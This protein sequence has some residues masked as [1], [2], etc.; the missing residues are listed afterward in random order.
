MKVIEKFGAMVGDAALKDPEKARRLLL[1][2]YRLQEQRLRFFPDKEIPPSGQ[3]AALVVMKNMIQ[4]LAKPD[5]A[6]MVSIFVPGELVTAAGLTPY[7][8]EAISCFLAG[9]KCEQAF[10]RKTL[11]EGFPETMCSYHRVFLGAALTEILP[12]PRCMIYTNLA[13][14]GNMMTFPYLKQTCDRPGFYIDVPYEK[15]RESVLY[16]ADQLRKL[17]SFLEDVTGRKI[18]EEAVRQS[19]LNSKKAAE[20][21]RKQLELRKDHDPVTSLTYELYAI[22][23][24]HLLAGSETAVRYTKLLLE[25][26]KKAPKGEGLHILWMHIMPF[27]QEPVKEVFNYSKTVHLSACDFVADGFRQMQSDDPYEAMAEKMVYCIYNGNVS[28][29]IELAK[30]LARITNADGGILFAHWGCK[31]T[32]GASGLI[33]NSLEKAELLTMVLDGDGCNPANTSDGQVST[34]L[35]AFLEMLEENR[36]KKNL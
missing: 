18:S 3:Y 8:V 21:Y 4:A 19:V 20:N 13:C 32:I 35:Q 7:S 28:Q 34:R 33:K 5:N 12:K 25:D 17:K 26:V 24:C 6:A 27:L 30:E 36:E 9:T 31:G 22:F 16:V 1:T 14:D 2:G 15:N 23:M 29:R 11:E 10:L